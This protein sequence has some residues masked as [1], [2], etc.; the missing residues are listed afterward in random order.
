MNAIQE[1]RLLKLADFLQELPKEKFDFA[2]IVREEQNSK[3]KTCGTVCC[4][5]GWLPKIFP[6][7]WKWDVCGLGVGAA[8][9]NSRVSSDIWLWVSNSAEFFG[10]PREAARLLFTANMLRPWA[11]G[12]SR[13]HKSATAKQVATSI[14]QFIRWFK[15]NPNYGF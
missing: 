6:R 11:R 4:A 10:I 5:V 7:H 3:G 13:L 8:Y 12:C 2:H 15:K 9:V 1:K 14:R